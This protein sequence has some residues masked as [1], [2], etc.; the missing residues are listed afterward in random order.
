LSFRTS[1][2]L[3][4]AYGVAVTAAMMVDTLLACIVA[5]RL[6]NWHPAAV[7]LMGAC[8]FALDA[9]FLGSNLL[10]VFSGGF[11]PL[12]V[13][14]GMLTLMMTWRRGRK[15]LHEKLKENTLP[16]EPF[17]ESLQ[18]DR[19]VTV[20]GTAIFMI[21]TPN[22]VPHAL[23]HNLK[24]NKVLHERNILLTIYT[25]D[26]P[27]VAPENRIRIRKLEG[28][29]YV[30]KAYYGF[31]ESPD[32]PVLL[33]ECSKHGLSF[34]MMETSFFLSR[35]RLIAAARPSM[36]I[37]FEKIFSAMNK[38]AMNATDFFNIPTNRVVELGTQIEI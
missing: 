33:E 6:W 27:L 4:T 22:I 30:L 7:L 36:P 15:V 31:K 24:H 19:P 17:I 25:E 14:F 35:E 29:F 5:R 8:F 37:V 2:N 1:S 18:Q 23:L 13:G 34:N 20:P 28:G 10:K 26:I 32:V 16:L 21:S 11:F 9:A 38:N 3:A 12:L